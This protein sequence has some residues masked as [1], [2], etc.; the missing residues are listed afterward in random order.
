LNLQKANFT[1][2][3]T[4]TDFSESSASALERGFLVAKGGGAR[5]SIIHAVEDGVVTSLQ[6]LFEEAFDPLSK[7][8]EE[9]ARQQLA[10]VVSAAGRNYGVCAETRLEHGPAWASVCSVA[11]TTDVGLII[12]GAHG[13]GF[14]SRPSIGST[15]S[16]IL[17]QSRKPVLIVK[18]RP[19]QAY[20][21][22][23]VPT[24]FSPVS[25][26]GPSGRTEVM[27]PI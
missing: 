4:A 11:D 27:P 2:I 10:D 23:L 19:D 3:L 22:V 7:N 6:R 5:F 15:V 17:H 26:V 9:K 20:K 16:R 8:V 13:G 21:R 24:D 1:H 12:L 18:R 14:L 25:G